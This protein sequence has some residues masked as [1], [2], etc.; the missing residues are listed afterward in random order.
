MASNSNLKATTTT[1]R[2]C[3]H[4]YVGVYGQMYFCQ[5][6]DGMALPCTHSRRIT[7]QVQPTV[8]LLTKLDELHPEV[9]TE[10]DIN[11][12]DYNGSLVF[13]SA[14]EKIR[15]SFIASSTPTR[16]GF[17][18]KILNDLAI[19]KLIKGYQHVGG[20]RRHDFTVE[21][22]K[23][24]NYYVALEVKG[25]EGNSINISDRPLFADEFC[26]WSHL[27][28][29]IVN[30][31]AHGAKAIVGRVAN[32]LVRYEKQVDAIYFRDALCGTTARPCPKYRDAPVNI[33]PAPDIFLMPRRIPTVEDPSPPIHTLDTLQ[34]PLLLLRAFDVAENDYKNHIWQVHVSIETLESMRLRRVFRLV[35]NGEVVSEGRSNPWNR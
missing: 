22:E 35:H 29:A 1:N 21:I 10:H 28:G 33:S 25:G 13:R 31:P 12:P 6:C 11:P 30:Q 14:V 24:S 16:E 7:A 27:D 23:P 4:D 32:A 18:G 34:F 9:L 19:R 26:I 20:G 8:D 3:Y 5:Q 2:I 17:V 15:G